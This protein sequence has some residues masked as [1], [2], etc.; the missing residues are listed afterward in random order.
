MEGAV[1]SLQQLRTTPPAVTS[2]AQQQ[3]QPL[4][5]TKT[6]WPSTSP[7]LLCSKLNF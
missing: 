2:D 4:Q 1:C 6:G 3:Q 5:T 7:T